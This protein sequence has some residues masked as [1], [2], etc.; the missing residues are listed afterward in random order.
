MKLLFAVYLTSFLCFNSTSQY[1]NLDTLTYISLEEALSIPALEV[2]AL[3]LSK[4][5]LSE[6]P[7]TIRYFTNLKGIKLTKNKLTQLPDFFKAYDSLTFVHLSKNKFI[8]FPYVLFHCNAIQLIDISRNK[9]TAVPAGIGALQ[10]LT[11]LDIWNNEITDF[12]IAFT[13]L[14]QL[15]YLD[16]RGITFSPSF[17][18]KWTNLLPDTKI[19]FDAPCKCLE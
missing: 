1:K 11:H 10:N 5:K 9:L 7:D 14:P 16:A 13:Q 8:H 4:Q 12:P 15:I 17:L 6:I 2:V 18:E 19:M 3:D